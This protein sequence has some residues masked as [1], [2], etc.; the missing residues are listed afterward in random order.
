MR[1]FV[2]SATPATFPESQASGQWPKI[3]V[4]SQHFPTHTH[5]GCTS[6]FVHFSQLDPHGFVEAYA[7][8]Q[9]LLRCQLQR[10]L[11][12][13]TMRYSQ[14]REIK[15]RQFPLI[16]YQAR[17]VSFYLIDSLFVFLFYPSA[18][19]IM[20]RPATCVCASDSPGMSSLVALSGGSNLVFVFQQPRI[21]RRALISTHGQNF[22]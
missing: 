20:A 2:A 17:H 16:A 4:R 21:T 15:T 22:F 10:A 9:Y 6:H 8:I 11:L 3:I 7:G 18:F 19:F 5:L 1:T 13:K 14:T 12:G